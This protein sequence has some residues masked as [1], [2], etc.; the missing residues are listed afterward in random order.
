MTPIA[1]DSM[2]RSKIEFTFI[3]ILFTFY[4]EYLKLEFIYSIG[5]KTVGLYLICNRISG[6]VGV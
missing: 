1:Q 2:N 6:F 3:Y 5:N 4:Y